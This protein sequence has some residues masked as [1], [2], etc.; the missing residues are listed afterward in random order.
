MENDFH[1][2]QSALQSALKEMRTIS[3]GLRLPE[4]GRLSPAETVARAVSDY[5]RKSGQTVMLQVTEAPPEAP[6]PLKITLYRL[7]QESLANGFRHAN[8]IGQRVAIAG[9]DGQ[10]TIEVSDAGQG[11]DINAVISEGHLGLDAMRERV[12]ILGGTFEVRSGISQGTIIRA[13]LP[14]SVPGVEDE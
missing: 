9:R 1:T 8:G 14:L 12:E 10:L 2:V 11:F 13:N 7:V 5:E 6:L 3:A 4:I